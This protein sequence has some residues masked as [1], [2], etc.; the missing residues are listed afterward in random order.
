MIRNAYI[1]Y[2]LN[3]DNLWDGIRFG[4]VTRWLPWNRF[5]VE[6]NAGYYDKGYR[7]IFAMNTEGEV[8]EP[9]RER[10]D[11]LW[12]FKV[13]ASYDF[14]KWGMI[15][16]WSYRDNDSTDSYFTY[17]MMTVSVGIG[18]YL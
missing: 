17:S 12:F 14:E 15:A 9:R 8:V 4:F 2:P 5:S 11:K 1:L 7:G 3:D 13:T 10:E 16:S 18:Y 6:A